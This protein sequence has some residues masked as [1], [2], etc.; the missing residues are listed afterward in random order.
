MPTQ[1]NHEIL[2]SVSRAEMRPEAMAPT[3]TNATVHVA[4]M[5]MALSAVEM[6]MKAAAA[7]MVRASWRQC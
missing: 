3:A 2:L 7:T 5:L 4:C 6:P 1:L